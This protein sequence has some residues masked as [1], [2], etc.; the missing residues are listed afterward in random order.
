LQDKFW[1]LVG[2]WKENTPFNAYTVTFH[3]MSSSK[4]SMLRDR[5]Y[6]GSRTIGDWPI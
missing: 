1:L 3:S 2:L 5:F 6:R 4:K